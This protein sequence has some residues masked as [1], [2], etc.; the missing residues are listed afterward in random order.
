MVADLAKAGFPTV[1]EQIL[2]AGRT[3]YRVILNQ[4]FPPDEVRTALIRLKEAGF[5]GAILP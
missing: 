4:A 2:L 5:E 3:Y 1:V